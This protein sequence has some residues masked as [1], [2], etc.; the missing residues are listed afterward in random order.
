MCVCV[1]TC[2]C[3]LR[4]V[5]V[6]IFTHALAEVWK[7]EDC[8]LESVFSYYPV[9]PEHG[10]QI[11]RQ[12]SRSFYPRSHL[13]SLEVPCLN[14]QM[15]SACGLGQECH[16]SQDWVAVSH[17]VPAAHERSAGES[18]IGRALCFVHLQSL[19]FWVPDNLSSATEIPAANVIGSYLLK[20][21]PGQ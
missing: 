1:H 2:E 6:H 17:A 3:T 12:G 20:L 19:S 13:T 7:S 21:H 18:D 4:H 10:T 15:F 16:R 5:S 11:D 9:A 14:K 8:F